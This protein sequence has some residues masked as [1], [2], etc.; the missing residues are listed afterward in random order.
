MW[1]ESDELEK[2][3]LKELE[4]YKDWIVDIPKTKKE[5]IQRFG[6]WNSK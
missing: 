6:Q 2:Q 3:V 1:M 5:F 4:S